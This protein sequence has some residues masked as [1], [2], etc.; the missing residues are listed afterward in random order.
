MLENQDLV[1]VSVMDW[2][3]PF[4]SS[5]HHLMRELARRNR[6]LFVDNQWNPL[7]AWKR[8]RE[9]AVARK[10]A[11]WSGRAPSTVEVEPNLYVHTPWPSLPMG[12]VSQRPLF[13]GLYALNQRLLAASVRRAAAKL[14]MHRPI[15]WISF[16]VLSSEILTTALAPRL[17]IYHV[18]DEI[19]A[20]AGVSP[21]AGEIEERLLTRAD[22][23]LASS[24]QLAADK[25]R[26]NPRTHW[27]P[28]GAD[29]D[30]FERAL[31]AQTPLHPVPAE[32]PGPV[33]AFCGHLEERVDFALLA[34]LAEARPEWTFAIAGP[35]A[36]SRR[37]E[38]TAL[39]ARPNVR[40]AGLLPRAELPGFLKG[41]DA[42]V[43]PFVHSAQTRAIY[44]LKLNEYLAAGLPVVATPFADMSGFEGV[45]RLADDPEAFAAALEE[46]IAER[47]APERIAERVALARSNRWEARAEAIGALLHE[48][49][50]LMPR[51]SA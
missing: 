15:L 25:G 37:A 22:L 39:F 30:L 31:G 19:T 41:A 6:V 40:Y 3:H 33:V 18:T 50:F 35:V 48:A 10:L 46:A 4:Q 9:P 13:A 38:A 5:R 12:R 34:A 16:N 1:C 23:V 11:V 27:V 2:E 45:V 51:A 20:M 28:N 47:H 21:F 7:A 32:A 42:A 24:T 29:T 17:T 44:P 8:R 14:G 43:I 26:L 36:P 49:L